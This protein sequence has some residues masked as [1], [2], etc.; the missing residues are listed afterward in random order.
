MYLLASER[1]Q[2][3]VVAVCGSLF[4]LVTVGLAMTVL[5]ERVSRVQGAGVVAA[6]AGV[7]LIAL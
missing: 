5:G 6:V 1:G 7:C 4:P 3:S 2:L